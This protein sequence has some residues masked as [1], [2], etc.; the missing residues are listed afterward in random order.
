[1]VKANNCLYLAHFYVFLCK[2][3]I[4]EQIFMQKNEMLVL[5]AILIRT[6]FEM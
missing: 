3:H 6:N 5:I 4:R 1:M 2:S